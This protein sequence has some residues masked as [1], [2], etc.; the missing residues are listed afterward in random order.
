[1]KCAVLTFGEPGGSFQTI[2]RG[3]YAYIRYLEQFGHQVIHADRDSCRRPWILLRKLKSWKPDVILAQHAGAMLSAIWRRIGVL[4]CPVVHAWDDYYAEQSRLPAW[5]V[6]PFEKFSVTGADH[7]TSVSRYNVHLA[8]QWGKPVTFIPHGVTP[9]Q[10]PGQMVLNSTRLKVVYLGDQSLYKGMRMLMDAMRGADAELFMVGTVN[11]DL[12]GIAPG[13]VRFMGK[14]PP[15]EVQ[16]VLQQADVLVNPSDQD[17]NFKLQEYIRA[18][19]PILGVKG[20]MEWAFEHGRDAWLADDL[21]DGLKRL[22]ADAGLRTALAEGVRRLP[23]L[24]WEQVVRRLEGVLLQT[25]F[26]RSI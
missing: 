19:K 9:E 23:V 21:A 7:I 20:R 8:G 15:Q 6:W 12:Q 24:T 22:S 14:I 1:M 5:V 26:G 2:P 3:T 16:S 13:N 4:P 25:A 18:G 11:P 17:S 10:R